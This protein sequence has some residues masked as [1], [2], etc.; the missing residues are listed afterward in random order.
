MP[1]ELLKITPYSS[2]GNIGWEDFDFV[3][4]FS[5]TRC[6]LLRQFARELKKRGVDVSCGA[7][8]FES[9]GEFNEHMELV[10]AE[11]D[12]PIWAAVCAL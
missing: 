6:S 4:W 2:N 9:Y 3:D 7:Y 5:A 8:K 12:L 10:E 11:T 1:Y